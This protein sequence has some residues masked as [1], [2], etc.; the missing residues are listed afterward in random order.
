MVWMSSNGTRIGQ[1]PTTASVVICGA[2]SISETSV[3]VPP[4]SK[5]MTLTPGSSPWKG[6]GDAS[7]AT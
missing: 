3:E 4:M 2:P 6:E 5:V 7:L 1:P